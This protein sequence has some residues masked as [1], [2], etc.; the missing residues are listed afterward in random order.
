VS[1]LCLRMFGYCHFAVCADTRTSP[2]PTASSPG[3]T[4]VRAHPVSLGKRAV[5]KAETVYAR[6]CRACPPGGMAQR[7]NLR[8]RTCECNIGPV[9]RRHQKAEQAPGWHLDQPEPGVMTWRLPSGRV[10]QTT[11]DPPSAARDHSAAA[12]P[13]A[14]Q[15]E[16]VHRPVWHARQVSSRALSS[17][18]LF[19]RAS[20]ANRGRA[21]SLSCCRWSKS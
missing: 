7:P 5:P 13:S 3:S 21:A 4:A 8:G 18:G 10:Y 20:W 6:A 1:P 19:H 12:P 16:P 17:R 2:A 11:G 9:C 15:A 14:R